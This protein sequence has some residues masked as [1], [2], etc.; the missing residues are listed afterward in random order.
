MKRF[1]EGVIPVNFFMFNKVLR[2]IL[3]KAKMTVDDVD[4]F[5]YPTF[6]TWDQ[7]YFSKATGIPFEKIYTRRLKERGH[8]QECDMVINYADAVTDE[9]IKKGD[10]VMAISN[11]AGFAWSAVI[12][13][14]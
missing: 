2:Q 14:H 12:L 11:G 7:D 1:N 4:V 5:I 8:V 13:R 6:S 3:A 9:F 10:V